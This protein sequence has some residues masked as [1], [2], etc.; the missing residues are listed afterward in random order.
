MIER[1][2]EREKENESEGEGE[3]DMRD[4]KRERSRERRKFQNSALVNGRKHVWVCV[5]VCM[6]RHVY[7]WVNVCE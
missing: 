7:E 5:Y 1:E 6:S 3:R 2:R 4:K